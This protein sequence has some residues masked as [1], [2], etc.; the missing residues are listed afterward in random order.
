LRLGLEKVL[1]I[2]DCGEGERVG[3]VDVLEVAATVV[4]VNTVRQAGLVVVWAVGVGVACGTGADSAR[5]RALR[6]SKSAGGEAERHRDEGKHGRHSECGG[7]EEVVD[8]G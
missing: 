6:S 8:V 2:E 1:T 5:C 7:S 3:G 4:E